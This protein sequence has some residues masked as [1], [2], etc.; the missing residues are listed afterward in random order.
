M[1]ACAAPPRR[2]R[3]RGPTPRTH[4]SHLSAKRSR[5]ASPARARLG[6]A[7]RSIDMTRLRTTARRDSR[8]LASLTRSGVA[9]IGV[10][11]TLAASASIATAQNLLVPMDDAQQNHLKAYGLTFN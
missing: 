2:D 11:L 3:G 4:D 9:A 1:G 10:L 6:Q 7:K 8:R 5:A